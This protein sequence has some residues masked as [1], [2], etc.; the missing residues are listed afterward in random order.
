MS[1][2]CRLILRAVHPSGPASLI[3][4]HAPILLHPDELAGTQGRGSPHQRVGADRAT[5]QLL[6]QPHRR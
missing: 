4:K 2:F 6:V 5:M 1:R 3:A